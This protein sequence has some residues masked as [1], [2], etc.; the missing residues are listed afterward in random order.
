MK[1]KLLN[2]FKSLFK[3]ID[4]KIVGT[5]QHYKM[6]ENKFTTLGLCNS[7]YSNVLDKGIFKVANAIFVNNATFNNYLN[8]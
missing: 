3:I 1:T 8:S 6:T 2:F 7:E 5:S 4:K